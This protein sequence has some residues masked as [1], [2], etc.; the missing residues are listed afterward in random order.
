MIIRNGVLFTQDN[1]LKQADLLL[2]GGRIVQI[3]PAGSLEGE[4]IDARGNYV[5]PGF[6]D[7]HTHAC[8]NSD[9][10]DADA[11]GI[12]RMLAY[13]GK[14]GITSVV[15]ATMSFDEPILADVL[16][17]IL[18]FFERE[19]TGAVLR[20]INMEGP[21]FNRVKKGAQ[22]DQYIMD[23]SIEMFDNLFGLCDG[24]I[25]LVSVAPEL[26]GGMEFIRAASKHCTVSVA[27]TEADYEIAM[28]AFEAGA[29]HVTHLFNAMSPFLH[30]APGV[31][32]AAFDKAEHVEVI[33]DGFHL[34][35]S[36][37][38]SAFAWFG[39]GRICLV[40]DSMRGTGMPDGA[41]YS[42]GG[43][44]VIMKEGKATL[45]DGTIAGSTTNLAECCRRAIGFGVPIEQALRAATENPARAAG[46]FG[47]VGSLMPGK[48]ADLVFWDKEF[49]TRAVF[50][51]G[52]MIANTRI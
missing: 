4:A 52:E 8:V 36:V 10:C 38:R 3:A 44:R 27:H 49:N 13:Y 28:A 1:T 21:F 32:G 15:P 20:G 2:E 31:V 33:S 23:P 16:K 34:H 9:F 30:R 40:S 12:A 22:N 14:E 42:L 18:P 48:R 29:S 47:E 35:P 7:I 26:P 41:D 25:R 11:D 37:V 39:A 24:R 17:T 43:L 19:G 50:F 6:V 46:I 51:G 5:L 45:E